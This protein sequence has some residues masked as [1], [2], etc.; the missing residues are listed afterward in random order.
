MGGKEKKKVEGA[1]DTAGD[2]IDKL[3]EISERIIENLR[4]AHEELQDRELSDALDSLATSDDLIS[5]SR[6]S[7]NLD[8]ASAE[9]KKKMHAIEALQD[10]LM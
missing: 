2:I 9:I 7:E 8:V 1:K 5:E 6:M 3:I 10:G 4:A